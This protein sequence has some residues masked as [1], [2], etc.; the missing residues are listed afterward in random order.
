MRASVF[1]DNMSPPVISP[2]VAIVLLNYNGLEDTRKCLGS[3]ERITHRP[4]LVIVVDNASRHDPTEILRYEFPWCMVM[5]SDSNEG[6]AGGNNIGIRYAL[7]KDADYV[8]L[9]NN[10]TVVSE[11]LVTSLVQAARGEPEFGIIGPVINDME[12]QDQVQTDGCLFNRADAQGF[13]QRK[14]IPHKRCSR[15]A[16][17]EVDIVNGCCM[18]VSKRVFEAIGLFDERFFLIHEESDFCLRAY[19]AGFHCGVTGES[20]VWHKHSASFARAGNW[21]QRYYD[22]RNLFLLLRTHPATRLDSRSKFPSWFAYCKH[23]YYCY[24]I[25]REHR[26]AEGV[27]AVVQGLCDALSGHFGPWVHREPICFRLMRGLL[28]TGWQLR[29]SRAAAKAPTNGYVVEK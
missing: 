13:F 1:N 12:Y 9:L 26:C 21:R 2:S 4:L 10:D 22:V 7:G 6:W 24:C 23:V 28:E 8:I 14:P 27:N 18:M 16:V 20:L 17:T 19:E 29:G 3:I 5:R 15:P 25:E 11:E